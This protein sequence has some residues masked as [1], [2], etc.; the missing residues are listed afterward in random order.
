MAL[1]ARHDVIADPRVFANLRVRAH[2]HAFVDTAAEVLGELA[3]MWRSD[4]RAAPALR[5]R[6][7]RID[8]LSAAAAAGHSGRDRARPM[9]TRKLRNVFVPFDR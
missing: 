7:G 4:C 5:R 9:M 1:S 8:S 2:P 3:E 6:T